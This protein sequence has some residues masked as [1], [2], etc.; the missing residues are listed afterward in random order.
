MPIDASVL[1]EFKTNYQ[2]MVERNSSAE[3]IAAL[4]KKWEQPLSV[5]KRVRQTSTDAADQSGINTVLDKAAFSQTVFRT[6]PSK[7]RVQNYNGM[8]EYNTCY[9]TS[10]D[11]NDDICEGYLTGQINNATDYGGGFEQSASRFPS[12]VSATYQVTNGTST[13]NGCTNAA[14]IS[15]LAWLNKYEGVA[16]TNSLPGYQPESATYS[17]QNNSMQYSTVKRG[18]IVDTFSKTGP[19]GQNSLVSA[20]QSSGVGSLYN[21]NYNSTGTTPGNAWRNRI[22]TWLQNQRAGGM[23][24]LRIVGNSTAGWGGSYSA[25]NDWGYT[26]Y[27]SNLLISRSS[28]NKPA[29]L[30]LPYIYAGGGNNQNTGQYHSSLLTKYKIHAVESGSHPNY[31]YSYDTGD[32]NVSTKD[33]P[34]DYGMPP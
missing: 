9:H 26:T 21:G 3:R 4:A 5:F 25:P 27:L 34:N 7:L 30:Q 10:N 29:I 8:T 6:I 1:S 12:S 11:S 20:S 33:W 31:S 32:V 16:L 17:M 19:S 18:G 23:D 13:V 24:N 2:K 15:M 14:I 28:L 22:N